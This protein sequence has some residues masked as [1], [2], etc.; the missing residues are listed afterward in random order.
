[1]SHIKTLVVFVPGE[2][3]LLVLLSKDG[4]HDQTVARYENSVY[5]V[6]DLD[7]IDD[8]QR[9]NE[10]YGIVHTLNCWLALIAVD[11]KD[12]LAAIEAIHRKVSGTYIM[13]PGAISDFSHM[14]IRLLEE[15]HNKIVDLVSFADRKRVTLESIAPFKEWL[16][17]LGV[18]EHS[19]GKS[20]CL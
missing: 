11:G 4:S 15:Y 8:Y 5:T 10:T 16:R 9:V 7:P 13:A 20:D 6:L 2:S 1:M 19:Q 17:S 14:L 18:R 12:I 3:R